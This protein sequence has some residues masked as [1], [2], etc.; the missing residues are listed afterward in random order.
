[1]AKLFS[2]CGCSRKFFSLLFAIS[3]QNMAT[4]TKSGKGKL[5]HDTQGLG[6]AGRQTESGGDAPSLRGIQ[7]SLGLFLALAFL[8]GI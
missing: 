1:M 7:L 8:E 6:D 5:T 4:R 3:Q 2:T